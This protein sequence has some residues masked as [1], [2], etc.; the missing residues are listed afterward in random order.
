M[1][2]FWHHP[3]DYQKKGI[4][5]GLVVADFLPWIWRQTSGEVDLRQN[6][7]RGQRYSSSDG[8]SITFPTAIVTTT[9]TIIM[10]WLWNLSIPVN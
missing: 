6:F 9:M 5:L 8:F 2:I 1:T 7:F 3:D 4:D 10:G